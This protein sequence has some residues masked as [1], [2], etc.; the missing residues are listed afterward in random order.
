LAR[1]QLAQFED[2]VRGMMTG[3][4]KVLE[5]TI[6][7]EARRSEQ[8]RL[9]RAEALSLGQL[10]RQQELLQEETAGFGTKMSQSEVFQLALEGAAQDMARAAELLSQRQT[11][12]PAQRSERN[13][14]ARLTQLLEAFAD[15]GKQSEE[16]QSAGG[17]KGG[18]SGGQKT[19]DISE[20]K[21]V[22]L[23]QQDISRRTAELEQQLPGGGNL[24]DAQQGEFE[25]LRQEQGKLADL[26]FDLLE[27]A[28][29]AADGEDLEN[30]P[31][32]LDEIL[33]K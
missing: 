5:E 1:E 9:S 3:Q 21:L 20:L 23:L 4:Q 31:D 10:A 22:K 12:E 2:A 16:K 19:R 14:L 15:D 28:E 30:L 33:E 17:G 6:R 26:V 18:G 29:E 11:G 8:G 27:P 25:R 32:A 24:T 7:L 13:A